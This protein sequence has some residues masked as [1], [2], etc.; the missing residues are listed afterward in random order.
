MLFFL[1]DSIT[2]GYSAGLSDPAL[3]N[4]SFVGLTRTAL[5]NKYGNVGQGFVP[6]YSHYSF[7][8]TTYK[9]QWVLS[10]NW[11]VPPHVQSGVL[12][13]NKKLLP[14]KTA[15]TST[16]GPYNSCPYSS[17]KGDTATFT[18][19]GTSITIYYVKDSICGT[20]TYHVDNAKLVSIDG[21]SSIQYLTVV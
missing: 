2:E 11:T 19:T 9:E 4:D 7:S 16:Y 20:F 13:P 6:V 17:A 12:L 3:T 15:S 10:G 5:A 1:R 14:N 21:Y 8:G 18:F